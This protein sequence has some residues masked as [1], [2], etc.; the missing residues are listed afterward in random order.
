MTVSPNDL[1]WDCS[2]CYGTMTINGHA[3]QRLAWCMDMTPFWGTPAVRGENTLVPALGYVAEPY[4]PSQT[5][6]S[7]LL[8][9]NG[10]WD[11]LGVAVAAGASDSDLAAQLEE[12][13]AWLLANVVMT[14]PGNVT[15]PAVWTT[16]SAAVVNADVQVLGIPTPTLTPGA[17]YRSTLDLRVPGGDLHL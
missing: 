10:H 6:Y 16:P 2:D 4:Y 7:P 9:V 8:V 13:I 14:N 15:V 5:M 11:R 3:M 17:V 1:T 12:N